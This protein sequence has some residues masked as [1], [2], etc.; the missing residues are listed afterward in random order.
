V[1]VTIAAAFSYEKLKEFENSAR[2]N[3]QNRTD[4]LDTNR[5]T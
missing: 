4:V 3:R 1:L 5:E 2:H